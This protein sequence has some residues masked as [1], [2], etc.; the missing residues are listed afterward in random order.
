MKLEA[1]ALSGCCGPFAGSRCSTA[2]KLHRAPSDLTEKTS[3]AFRDADVCISLFPCGSEGF[4][5]PGSAMFPK[6]EFGGRIFEIVTS[7]AWEKKMPQAASSP[8]GTRLL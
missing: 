8:V 3:C 7:E 2:G 5:L 1:R 6:V 4:P